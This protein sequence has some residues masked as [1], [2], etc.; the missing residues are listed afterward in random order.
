M[1]KRYEQYHSFN[2][3]AA[4]IYGVNVA[5]LLNN[6]D[7][8]LGNAGVVDSSGLVTATMP[9][10]VFRDKYAY[11]TTEQLNDALTTIDEEC[12]K[13]IRISNEKIFI[14]DLTGDFLE[15]HEDE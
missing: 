7:W 11:L 4:D 10:D 3:A 5:I 13:K 12:F 2:C 14:T 1:K 8:L 6:F 15:V 9:I